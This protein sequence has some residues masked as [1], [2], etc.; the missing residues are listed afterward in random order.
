MHSLLILCRAELVKLLRRRLTWVLLGLLIAILGMRINNVYGHAFDEPPELAEP[1]LV[2]ALVILPE[3]YRLAATLPGL[4]KRA[5]LSFE[6]LNI[7]L[8]LLTTVSV[9]QEFTWGTMRTTLARGTGR[10]RLLIA[11][12]L[13]LAAI[14]AFYLSALWIACGI[15]GIFTTQSLHGRVDWSFVDGS[16]FAQEITALARTWLIIWPVIAL[17]MLFSVWLRNPG[18][19]LNLAAL[20]YGLD[21]LATVFSGAVLG[22]YLAALMEAGIDPQ[23]TV[24]GPTR[25]LPTLLPHFNTAVALHWGQ[26]G[27]IPE[28]DRTIVSTAEILNMPHGPGRC[29]IV[30][31]S[32]GIVAL[33]LAVWI[34]RRRDVTV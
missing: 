28:L 2:K 5:R 25:V 32:Y 21:F 31:L 16:F 11:K 12:F 33:G 23:K 6:W 9:G 1:E 13:A 14:A 3:D 10:I 4:F 26:P 30:L 34:F 7:F 22:V 27:K 17:A 19:A 24:I 15:L 29:M 20:A 8:I 18:S